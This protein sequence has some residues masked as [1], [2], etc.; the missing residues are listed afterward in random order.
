MSQLIV[1]FITS[2]DGNASAVGWPGWWGLESPGY[3]AWLDE[4]SERAVGAR[5]SALAP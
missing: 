2:L 1:D 3:L 4:R 5:G